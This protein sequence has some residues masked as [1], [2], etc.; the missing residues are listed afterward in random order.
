MWFEHAYTP[1]PLCCPTRQAFLAQASRGSRVPLN[2]DQNIKIPPLDPGEYSWPRDLKQAGYR[3]AYIG[4]WHVNPEHGPT[5]YG[6]DEHIG[7]RLYGAYRNKLFPDVRT[8]IRSWGSR[9]DTSR[10]QPHALAIG[11]GNR[12]DREY[13]R[14]GLTLAYTPGVHRA[15]P[16]VQACRAVCDY[17]DPDRIP[18]WRSFD[19]DF[20]GKPHSQKQQRTIGELRTT[21]GR[22]GRLL[23][24]GTTASSAS[25][26]M[27]SAGCLTS[28]ISLV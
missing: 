22:T 19:D 8:R 16:S 26:M 11:Q 12:V 4:K 6:Y 21:L 5:E 23:S 15:S 3:S 10:A 2:Y 13:T 14:G 7:E 27:Q 17:D 9:P 18:K 28:S 1:I 25:W 20:E 24:P